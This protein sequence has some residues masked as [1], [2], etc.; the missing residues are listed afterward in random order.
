MVRHTGWVKLCAIGLALIGSS[1]LGIVAQASPA[2]EATVDAN[3]NV[4]TCRPWSAVGNSIPAT[5][6]PTIAAIGTSAE[7]QAAMQRVH[8]AARSEVG[9][10]A[11]TWDQ[12][13]AARAQAYADVLGAQGDGSLN[14]A[15]WGDR[16]YDLR[17]GEGESLSGSVGAAAATPELLADNLYREKEYFQNGPIPDVS[18][19]CGNA[20]HYAGMIN[21]STTNFG[22]GISTAGNNRILVCRYSPAVMPCTVPIPEAGV[23]VSAYSP[24][25]GTACPDRRLLAVQNATRS[26]RNLPL[27]AWSDDMAA[28]AANALSRQIDGSRPAV[29]ERVAGTQGGTSSGRMPARALMQTFATAAT[30]NPN[31]MNPAMT[32][33][34][35]ASAVVPG[36][37]PQGTEH[38]HWV[39]CRWK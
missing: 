3:Y 24:N 19:R 14:H 9:A 21:A 15:T 27:L 29:P 17:G 34:G 2:A 7:F 33:V 20:G 18:N 35:C 12:G 30:P 31:L 13:L 25:G 11:L 39:S 32:Q 23:P 1:S 28:D 36:L 10:P 26:A 16:P 8:T 37:T 38:D 6:P 4:P 22:C 5:T